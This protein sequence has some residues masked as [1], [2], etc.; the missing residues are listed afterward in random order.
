MSA[1]MYPLASPGQQDLKDLKDLKVPR[2]H[3]VRRAP[4]GRRGCK[5]WPAEPQ[6]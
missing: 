2:G 5:V 3:Q 4:L 1:Q 6:Y